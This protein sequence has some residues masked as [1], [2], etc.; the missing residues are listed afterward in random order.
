[1]LQSCHIALVLIEL[2]ITNL[3]KKSFLKNVD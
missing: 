1:M 2:F 3:Y